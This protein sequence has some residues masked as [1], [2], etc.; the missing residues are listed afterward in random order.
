M[1]ERGTRKRG[2]RKSG[3]GGEPSRK[4][5]GCVEMENSEQEERMGREKKEENGVGNPGKGTNCFPIMVGR[6]TVC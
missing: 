5:F 3:A 2:G 1:E 6:K 4:R